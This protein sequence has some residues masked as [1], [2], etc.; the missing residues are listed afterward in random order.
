[1]QPVKATVQV[2]NTGKRAGDEVVQL[3]LHPLDPKRERASKEL[4]GFQRVHLQPGESRE[5]SFTITPAN[6]LRT[7]DETRDAYSVDPGK[8]EVQVGASSSDVRVRK[9]LS[10][11][12]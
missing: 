4:R 5:V 1:M 8:Y 3:Y 9:T 10:V 7:W 2:K 6:D 11:T 12:K